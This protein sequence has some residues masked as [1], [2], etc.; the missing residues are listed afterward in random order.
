[1]KQI[2]GMLVITGVIALAVIL[3]WPSLMSPPTPVESG[4]TLSATSLI[5]FDPAVK[6]EWVDRNAGVARIPIDRAIDIL[7]EK[8][9]PW[10]IVKEE[11]APVLEAGKSVDEMKPASPGLDPAVV[12]IGQALFT[13]YRCAGCHIGNPTFPPLAG[14]YGQRVPLE[15]GSEVLFNDDYIRD[16]ILIPNDKIAAGNKPV[17]PGYKDRITED[18][19]KQIIVY[20]RSLK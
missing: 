1:M 14:K 15:G 8:G 19:I 18:E 11:P 17:M 9:L 6:Y 5:A 13:M 12:Q 4:R 20:I 3:L 10:G 7:A 16:S 2:Y